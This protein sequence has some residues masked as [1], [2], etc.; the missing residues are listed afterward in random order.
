MKEFERMKKMNTA[1]NMEVRNAPNT[2][3]SVLTRLFLRVAW[4]AIFGMTSSAYAV[5][6]T[7]PVFSLSM[8]HDGV[9]ISAGNETLAYSS[10]WIGDDPSATVVIADNG[11][12]VF[13]GSGEGDFAWA[14]SDVGKHTLT[15]TTYIN[16]E[17]QEEVYEATV[18]AGF[19]YEVADGKATVVSASVDSGKVVVPLEI[20]GFKV[21]GIADGVFVGYDE[22]K[23]VMMPGVFCSS[24]AEVFPDSYMSITNVTLTGNIA[25]LPTGAFAGCAALESVTLAQSGA[26]IALGG[27]KGWNFDE[28]GVLRS[29]NITH[30]EESSMRMAVQGEGRLSYRWKASSEYFKSFISDYAYLSVDGIAKGAC[31]SYVLSGAAIG[32]A[33]DW[34]E[35]SLE[36][37]GD[38]EHQIDWTFVKNDNDAGTVGEDCVWV[39]EITYEPF[40]RLTFDVDGAVGVAPD[41]IK[42]VCGGRIILPTAN[43]FAKAK[44]TFIGWSDGVATYAPGA[45]YEVGV[46]DIVLTA[47]YEANTLAVPV[48]SSADVSSGGEIMTESATIEIVAEEGT[49]IYY[50]LDGTMPTSESLLYSGAFEANSLG[51]VTVKAIAVRDNCFDS[52]VAEFTFTRRPFTAAECLNANG[53]IFAVGGDADWTRVLGDASHDGDVALRSGV[54]SDGQ[55]SFIETKVDG[56]GTISFWWKSSCET[57]WNGMKFDY[58]SFTVDGVEQDFLGGD[59]DWTYVTVNVSGRDEHTLRWTYHKDISDSAGEDCAWLDEVVWTPDPIPELSLTATADE[60]AAALARSA[61]AKLAE[62]ITSAADYAAYRA[63]ALSV[64]GADGALAGSEAVK[65]SPNAYLLYALDAEI[66]IAEA[67]KDGDIDIDY[68]DC[69]LSDSTFKLTVKIK[70]VTVGSEALEANIKKV[71]GIEGSEKLD[72]GDFSVAV[73]NIKGIQIVDGSIRFTVAPPKTINGVKPERFFF[74]VKMFPASVAEYRVQLWEG[75]PYWATT[76]IGAEKPED[77]GYYFWWGDTVGYK[78][79]NNK[80]VASDG[81]NSNFIFTEGNTPTHEKSIST[82]KNEGWITSDGVLAPEHDAATVHWGNGWRMPTKDELSALNNYCDWMW[83]T[84]DGVKG[85]LIK[86][87]GAYASNSIFL[88]AAGDGRDTSLNGSGSSGY[89]WSSVPYSDDYNAWLLYFYSNYRSTDDFRRHYGRPVRPVLGFT[90]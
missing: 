9:R 33:M 29:G 18:Y 40:I 22:I 49:T 61:D 88:P 65:K 50:T 60:V 80:W 71:I 51:I 84:L 82:L 20:D 74:R 58:V 4:L 72:G 43:G 73:V 79:E 68:F 54:I 14:A 32:G 57:I 89:Y 34:Q 70:D 23:D 78:R 45:E 28:N 5:E 13:R 35:V 15:Y 8:K 27:E 53:M 25:Q 90:K 30:S 44:H 46:M 10:Q 16:G 69:S 17:A 11:A 41:Q 75:G 38:C 87:R 85:Y 2:R 52:E 77:S 3:K 21:T 62:N 1:N 63:W 36:V 76:N 83:I 24:M 66:L 56:S 39:D 59:S 26:T 55:S 42:D 81:S 6:A 47:V 64:K 48:I 67:I 86:G 31:N 19:K 12:E 7:S 37:E